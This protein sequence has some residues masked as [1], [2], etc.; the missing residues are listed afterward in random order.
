MK[1]V[2]YMIFGSEVPLAWLY[3]AQAFLVECMEL[4][5]RCGDTIKSI[6]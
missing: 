2:L 3:A 4:L 6:C 5:H 1:H